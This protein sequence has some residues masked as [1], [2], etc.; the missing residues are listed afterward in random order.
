M[1]DTNYNFEGVT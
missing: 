1:Y